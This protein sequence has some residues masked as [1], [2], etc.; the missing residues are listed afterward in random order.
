MVRQCGTLLWYVIVVPYCGTL[1][2]RYCGTL[3]W[4]LIVVRF[5]GMSTIYMYFFSLV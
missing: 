4:Y 5:C 2:W 1:L 3:L